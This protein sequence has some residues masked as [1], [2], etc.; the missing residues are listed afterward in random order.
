MGRVYCYF[1]SLL[2]TKR[3]KHK[4]Q[5]VIV[6]YFDPHLHREK[7]ELFYEFTL[8]IETP[9]STRLFYNEIHA[10]C[11]VALHTVSKQN[12]NKKK[13]NSDK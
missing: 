5:S 11:G 4:I 8:L 7:F 13:P 1:L 3:Q 9:F 12:S 2:H 10:L 6:L